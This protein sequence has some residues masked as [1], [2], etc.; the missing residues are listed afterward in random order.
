[1]PAAAGLAPQTPAVTRERAS[2]GPRQTSARSVDSHGAGAES[3]DRPA[4]ASDPGPRP[5]PPTVSTSSSSTSPAAAD[6]A[7]P[8]A[9]SRAQ[10]PSAL[11][12]FLGCEYRTYLDVL[13]AR[14]E[15]VGKRNPP[16]MELLLERGNRYEE[17]IIE[18]WRAEGRSVLTIERADRATRQRRVDETL[19]AMRAGRRSS[20]GV[21]RA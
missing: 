18:R 2:G 1:M 14:D 7:P 19:A 5:R 9:S 21:L 3:V 8:S 20:T 15:P 17:Q 12:R 4:P 6:G 16:N 13:E 11:S 10:Q